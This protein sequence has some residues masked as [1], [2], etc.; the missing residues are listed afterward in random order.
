MQKRTQFCGKS[1]VFHGE[2]DVQTPF[3]DA[4]ELRDRCKIRG[5]PLRSFH[6]YPELGHAFSPR[7]G[8]RGWK[9][10]QGPMD[11]RVQEDIAT[12]AKID[13]L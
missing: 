4:L 7:V 6:P 13:L 11:S 10:T 1:R 5:T 3:E 2:V 9:D 12:A 8:Y